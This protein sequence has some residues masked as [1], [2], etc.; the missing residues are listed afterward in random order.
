MIPLNCK[1]VN[2]IQHINRQ[3]VVDFRSLFIS[4]FDFSLHAGGQYSRLRHGMST[5]TGCKRT[6]QD[7]WRAVWHGSSS[8]GTG[9]TLC[10][11]CVKIRLNFA[12]MCAALLRLTL[13]R[14]KTLQKRKEIVILS[15]TRCDIGNYVHI[16][17]ACLVLLCHRAFKLSLPL[18][19]HY[20]KNDI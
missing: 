20:Y 16:S 1:A 6:L 9:R 15:G 2:V 18:E 14:S 3:S 11:I 4:L 13:Q 7:C 12:D 10:T 19:S 17:F 8:T 5:Q